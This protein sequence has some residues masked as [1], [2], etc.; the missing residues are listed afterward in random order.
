[1][2]QFINE[3]R[4]IK[5]KTDIKVAVMKGKQ[6]VCPDKLDYETCRARSEN[7][8]EL[9]EKERI[10]QKAKKELAEATDRFKKSKD[11]TD[12]AM[13]IEIEQEIKE[14]ESKLK[15]KRERICPHLY[16]VLQA[17]GTS[18]KKW[19]YD[20]VKSPEEI[21]D[22]AQDKGMCA[23]ELL[24]REIKHADLIICNYH[25]VLSEDIFMTFLKWLDKLPEDLIVIFD[26]AHNIENAARTHS[27]STLS[28]R[29]LDKAIQEIE[30]H[31][32]RFPELLKEESQKIFLFFIQ[33]IQE[34][35]NTA[36]GFGGQ[37]QV[38]HHWKD[39]QISD[40][41]ERFDRLKDRFLQKIADYNLAEKKKISIKSIQNMLLN[42][43]DVGNEIEYEYHERYKTGADAVMRKSGISRA[44]NFL[45][46]Y[47]L[48]SENPNYYP[49]LNIRRDIE[50]KE[51]YGRLE[52]FACIPRNVTAPLFASL[53]GLVLMSATFRPFAMAKEALG[54]EKQCLEI[55]YPMSFPKENRKTFAV[56]VGPLFSNSRNDES[57]RGAVE[58]ALMSAICAAKG[59]TIIYFQSFAEAEKY[60]SF[61]SSQEVLRRLNI[62]ILFD[63][64]GMSSN[65]VRE[66]FFK[67]GESGGR[68]VL[69][70]YIFGTLSE[71]VDYRDDRARSVIIVGVGYPALNDRV[72]AVEAAYDE[73]FGTG[74][75]WEFA[76]QNP[77]IRRIRQA[78]GRVVRSPADYGVRILLDTRF[79]KNP[80]KKL[81]KYSVFENFPE[82]ERSEFVDISPMQ[83]EE[84]L[85]FFFEE[86]TNDIIRP[87][88]HTKVNK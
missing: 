56:S 27:S 52:L 30:E 33:S 55:A 54:I 80:I 9:L 45:F 64:I 36:L 83:L 58:N 88:N 57:I 19:L 75:G 86:K 6:S 4:D 21:Y 18:I 12:N 22:Y 44:A 69:V 60:R 48:N 50:T 20:D 46:S 49:I 13:R 65:A 28:E 81:G 40:P 25:H 41:Y 17:D 72:R 78:M 37:N 53:G 82:E 26:E 10:Y 2:V 76:I 7:T 77:T 74:K 31:S 23:Y 34:S 43:A 68:S 38:T 79:Q 61:L 42:V 14:M 63:Q 5:R 66:E 29:V 1:M 16:E 73:V 35:Y 67:I 87:S 15:G 84:K 62:Q 47:L 24:K 71:G 11:S 3:A 85:S 32:A 51:V 70:S 39:I 8:Y 59:N